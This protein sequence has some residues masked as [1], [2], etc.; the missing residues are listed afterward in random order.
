ME[1]RWLG[2]AYSSPDEMS[3]EVLAANEMTRG[4]YEGFV[5]ERAERNRSAPRVG[6]PAPNFTAERLG[7]DG[8]A[9]ACSVS[10]RAW[11]PGG[12]RVRLVLRHPVPPPG[13][14]PGRD[15]RRVPGSGGLLC[16]LHPRGA[17]ERRLADRRQRHRG[18]GVRRADV[19]GGARHGR[20][21]F[22][23]GGQF[24]MPMLLDDITN[25]IDRLFAG[26]PMRLYL[27]DE[28]GTV[29]FRTVVG[30]PGFDLDAWEEAIRHHVDAQAGL[31]AQ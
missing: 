6:D 22:R 25:E 5:R 17:S 4:F 15:L 21:R 30:S 23:D 10:L 13:A 26:M 27:I 14:S 20:T 16:R 9:T 11:W 12:T 7:R 18:S 31:P 1:E 28:Q 8:S 24:E 29:V 3:D 2:T 19:N